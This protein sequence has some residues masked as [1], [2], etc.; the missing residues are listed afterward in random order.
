MAARVKTLHFGRSFLLY[1]GSWFNL[2]FLDQLFIDSDSAARAN[3]AGQSAKWL[4]TT[5]SNEFANGLTMGGM[6]F[7]QNNHS[8]LVLEIRG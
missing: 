4:V 2:A 5:L 3:R 7:H 1:D 6:D 8:Q